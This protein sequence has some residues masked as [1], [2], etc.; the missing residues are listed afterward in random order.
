MLDKSNN[1]RIIDLDHFG[2]RSG[3]KMSY[4]AAII[5]A[6]AIVTLIMCQI[7]RKRQKRLADIHQEDIELS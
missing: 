4:M 2:H 1:I 3:E 5:F 7:I 6:V